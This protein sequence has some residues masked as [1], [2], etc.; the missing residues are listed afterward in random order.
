MKFSTFGT[1]FT[2]HTGARELMDDLG[3]AMAADQP[4]KMLGGGNPA[5]P[6]GE[7]SFRAALAGLLRAEYGWP[8][9][10][11][12]IA[13]TGG[14]QSGFFLLFNLLAG[15]RPDGT[16]HRILLPLTPEYVGYQDLGVTGDIF[17]ARRPAIEQLG[18][19]LFKYHVDFE[20]LV[21]IGDV[22][23]IAQRCGASAHSPGRR[24]CRSFSTAPM[25]CRSRASSSPRS[26]H[27]GTTT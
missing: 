17:T 4:V 22:A 14:S 11:E 20:A 16:E 12:N 18:H 25:A 2:R 23:A 19:N 3:A 9:G 26:R 13:L 27:T 24:R 1:R 21:G 10:P 6:T 7:Q 15:S 8:L 5:H